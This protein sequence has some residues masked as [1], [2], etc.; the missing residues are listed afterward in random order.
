MSEAEA[1]F[2]VLYQSV[3]SDVVDAIERL[4]T[5]AP[6]RNLCRINALAFAAKEGLDEE[7]AIAG[8]LHACRLGLFELTRQE[9]EPARQQA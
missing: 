1:L 4:V 7:Q 6:D 8:F 9:S 5:E 2:G 3:P